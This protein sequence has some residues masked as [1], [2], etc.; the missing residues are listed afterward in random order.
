MLQDKGVIVTEHTL[1]IALAQRA[2]LPV[3]GDLEAFA[4]DVATTLAAHPGT[5]MIVY[6]EMHLCGV[7][8]L[9]ESERQQALRAGAVPLDSKLVRDLGVIAA[10]HGVWLCPGSIGEL[11]ADGGFYNTQLLFDPSGTLRSSYRKMFPWRP[12]E[13]HLYGTE[14]VVEPLDGAGV[15]GMSICYD[16]W[17]PEHSRNVAWLGADLVLNIVKT[18]SPDREQELTIARANAIV[19]QNTVASV[20]AAGPIGRGRS[21]IV[22]AEGFV[23]AEA[24]IGE[25]TLVFTHDPRRVA[26]VRE[27]GTMFSNRMWQQFRAG[28]PDIPLPLYA[29]RIDPASWEPRSAI[30]ADPVASSAR[31]DLTPSHHHTT[32]ESL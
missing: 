9:P 4:A 11:D 32:E 22:D 15:A 18:T 21:I 17:F 19:N 13:P 28:D 29:G 12:F 23:I 16:A 7:E 5:Q 26:A 10:L 25:D 27:R 6:P 1:Q 2:P 20:N 31:P 14:F 30:S 3:D 24:G 8:H